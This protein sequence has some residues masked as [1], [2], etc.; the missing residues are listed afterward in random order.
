MIRN[1]LLEIDCFHHLAV[2][3]KCLALALY[4]LS[5]LCD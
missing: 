1:S 5:T 3:P 4:L 2:G